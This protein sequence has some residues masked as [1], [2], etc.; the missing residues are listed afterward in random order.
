MGELSFKGFPFTN[1]FS[2]EQML[3]LQNDI[4]NDE[5]SPYVFVFI[6]YLTS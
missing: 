5:P 4:S 3:D 2:F 6:N 1:D